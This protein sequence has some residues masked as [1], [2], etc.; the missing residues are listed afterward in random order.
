M[1]AALYTTMIDITVSTELRKAVAKPMLNCSN[2]FYRS[3]AY[4]FLQK[5]TLPFSVRYPQFAM[6]AGQ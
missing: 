2:G 3:A 5:G 4:W 1:D 6:K